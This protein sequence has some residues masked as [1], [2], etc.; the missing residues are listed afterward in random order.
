M[1]AGGS[2]DAT[3]TG[4]DAAGP[5]SFR[6]SA[7]NFA[8]L[9]AALLSLF[10]VLEGA[11]RVFSRPPAPKGGYSPIRGHRSREPQNQA[12]YRDVEHAKAKAP[13]TKRIVF[14]GDSF[15]YGV[16]VLLD[17]TYPKRVERM[18]SSERGEKWESLV[19]A[20]PGIDTEQEAVILENEALVYSPDVV[21]VGYVLNDAE[22]PSSAERRRA[23]EWAEEEAAKAHPPLWRSSAFLSLMAGRLRATRENRKRIQNHR[24]LYAPGAPGFAAATQAF[25]RMAALCRDR[26]IPMVVLI[27][28]LFANPLDASYPFRDVHQQVAGAARGA[29][30]GVV[31]ALPFFEGLDWRLLVVEGAQ[32]EHPNELA[33][34]IAAQALTS[35]LEQTFGPSHPP[36]SPLK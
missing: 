22:D 33:H 9:T 29:G 13:G 24:S 12:G 19:F 31:D 35:A 27:F 16:G 5:R 8:L 3:R 7:F 2:P 18:L 26:G 25:G 14:V 28:P 34:R 36:S 17:D 20:V 23:A 30:A 6:A 32:D 4:V 21:V 15:T 11:V 1:R 10:A